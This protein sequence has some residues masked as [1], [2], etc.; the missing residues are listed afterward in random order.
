MNYKGL[1]IGLTTIDIQYFV[2]KFPDSNK[3]I[4]TKPP[5][6]LVGGPATNAAVA[7]SK[8]NNSAILAS[9][10]GQNS[11]SNFIDTDFVQTN[12]KH[13]DFAGQK[14]INPV[15]ASVVTANNG[16]RNIFTHNPEKIESSISAD[17]LFKKIQPDI[18]LLDGF[19]PEFSID[20][21]QTANKKGIPV[22]LDCGSWKPQ[23]NKLLVTA[24]WIRSI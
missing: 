3:K 17:E 9:A 4:K 6:I 5:E 12:I 7:F 22:V 10:V 23:Y 24:H 2:D 14:E 11:F 15:I 13:Y 20:C 19:Y 18:L 1:F 16:E 21:A 8:L